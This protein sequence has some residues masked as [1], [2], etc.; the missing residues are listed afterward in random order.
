MSESKK[1]ENSPKQVIKVYHCNDKDRVREYIKEDK[2]IDSMEDGYWLGNGMYFWDTQSN[3]E[4]WRK[5][6]IRKNNQKEYLIVSSF[7]KFSDD[8]ILDLTDLNT[9]RKVENLWDKIALKEK[10]SKNPPLGKKLNMIYKIMP[11]FEVIKVI[12]VYP[13]TPKTELFSQPKRS[14]SPHADNKNKV[15]YSVKTHK[16]LFEK[17]VID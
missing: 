13:K 3:A 1:I 12:G 7:L 9:Q 16:C 8:E 5:E 2:I 4:Y 11:F 17:K 10:Y 15:I 6:K 14:D